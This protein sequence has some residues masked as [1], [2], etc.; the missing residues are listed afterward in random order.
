MKQM[1][2]LLLAFI[3]FISVSLMFSKMFTPIYLH[4][5]QGDISILSSLTDAGYTTK[6]S[7]GVYTK[8]GIKVDVNNKSITSED[9]DKNLKW[10][11]TN[12]K[13]IEL[14]DLMEVYT[15][16]SVEH[17]PARGIYIVFEHKYSIKKSFTTSMFVKVG[18]K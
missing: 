1:S 6:I 12:I 7:D 11:N 14:I 3:I 10:S 4:Q 17:I 9:G 16:T 18:D 2:M 15:P 8:N 13:S 5:A